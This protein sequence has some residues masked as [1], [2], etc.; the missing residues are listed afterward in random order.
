M[1]F[2]RATTPGRN[3]TKFASR[4]NRADVDYENQCLRRTRLAAGESQ[5][6]R[7]LKIAA[8]RATTPSIA[9]IGP[10]TKPPNQFLYEYETLC[11]GSSN[12]EAMAVTPTTPHRRRLSLVRR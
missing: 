8:N 6:L 4:R 7:Q 9:T 1:R 2:C 11:H 10:N 12:P 5:I 3:T